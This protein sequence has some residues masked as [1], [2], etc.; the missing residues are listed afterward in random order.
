MRHYFIATEDL[1]VWGGFLV[2]NRYGDGSTYKEG[3]AFLISEERS[4]AGFQH[5][6]NVLCP[7]GRQY[8]IDI[9]ALLWLMKAI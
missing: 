6:H 1:R 7:D 3:S 9:P 8:L 4:F 2:A 5:V